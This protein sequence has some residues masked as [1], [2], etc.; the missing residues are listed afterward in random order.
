MFIQEPTA[1]LNVF[2]NE[3]NKQKKT[4]A[5]SLKH[6]QE[7]KIKEILNPIKEMLNKKKT[8]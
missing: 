3:P 8:A 2:L 4:P 6:H 1:E 7:K 5:S